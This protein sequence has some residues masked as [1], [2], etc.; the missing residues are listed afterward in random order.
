VVSNGYGRERGELGAGGLARSQGGRMRC[1]VWR[2]AECGICVRCVVNMRRVKPGCSVWR[3]VGDTRGGVDVV[4]SRAV[5]RTPSLVSGR[6]ASFVTRRQGSALG[7]GQASNLAHARM[8]EA[9]RSYSCGMSL[10]RLFI[11]SNWHYPGD[12]LYRCAIWL[13]SGSIYC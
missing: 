11:W 13:V 10:Q 4:E 6:Q 12:F 9:K 1:R 7:G 2:W 3:G 8:D 5:E